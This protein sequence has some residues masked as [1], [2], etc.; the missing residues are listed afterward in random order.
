[1][2]NRSQYLTP[3]T[4][5]VVYYSDITPNMDV[6]P[7]TRQLALVT[8]EQDVYN[9]LLRRVMS[10]RYE[11]EYETYGGDVRK[12]LFEPMD[13]ATAMTLQAALEQ[14]CKQE[15]RANISSVAVNP[16]YGEDSYSITISFT[17]IN[18][19]ETITLSTILKRIR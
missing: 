14:V 9:S 11:R 13:P 7:M 8:N 3:Q 6:N 10:S 16:V 5:K 18:N 15:S 12:L 19:P 4:K 2:G 1:M 17:V